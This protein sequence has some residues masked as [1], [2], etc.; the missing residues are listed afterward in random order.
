MYIF[1]SIFINDGK[2]HQTKLLPIFNEHQGFHSFI[3]C[4]LSGWRGQQLKQGNADTPLLGHIH[5]FLLG[6]T[7]TFP[8]QPRDIISPACPPS[9]PGPPPRMG[10]LNHLNW[11]LSTWR[12]SV[13]NLSLSEMSK[14]LNLSLRLSPATLR[15]KLISAA[16]ICNLILSVTTQSS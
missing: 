3:F 14:L 15:R 12:S 1:S 5:Q 11:L 2:L 8:G 16:C 6:D 7:E 9:A 4:C 13:S 10:C